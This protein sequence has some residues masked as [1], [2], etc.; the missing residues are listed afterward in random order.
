MT[1]VWCTSAFFLLTFS[2]GAAQRQLIE[3]TVAKLGVVYADCIADSFAVGAEDGSVQQL[4]WS[5]LEAFATSTAS[6]TFNVTVFS[7]PCAT[8][9]CCDLDVVVRAGG[10]STG[11]CTTSTGT[12]GPC[13][14]LA[15]AQA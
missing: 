3:D 15:L 14:T 11:S 1:R 10:I 13:W 2:Y 12:L 6:P 5:E 8:H 7:T 4:S 9:G